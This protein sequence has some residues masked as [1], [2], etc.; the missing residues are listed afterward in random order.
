MKRMIVLHLFFLLGI[1]SIYSQSLKRI[2]LFDRYTKG[3]VLMKNYSLVPVTLNY[4]AANCNMMYMEGENEMILDN[5]QRIDT[6][7]IGKSKFIPFGQKGFTEV[8]S[9]KNGTVYIYWKLTNQLVG[10]KGAYGQVVQGTVETLNINMVKQQAGYEGR[11]QNVTDV[12]MRRNQNEYWL[13]RNGK[14]LKCKDKKSLLKLFA[15]KEE[16]IKEYIKEHKPEFGDPHQ[17]LQLLN[18]CMGIALYDGETPVKG[19]TGLSSDR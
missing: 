2:Y 6:V 11:E 10:K 19:M 8:H 3:Y 17:V 18:Y 7:F 15:N 14:L 5:L 12:Y 13:L 4:D 9:L 16:P 1:Y